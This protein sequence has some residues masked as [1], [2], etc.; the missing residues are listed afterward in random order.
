MH[1]FFLIVTPEGGASF[2]VQLM[3]KIVHL[4]RDGKTMRYLIRAENF[5]NLPE[6]LRE[7]DEHTG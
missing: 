3:K 2:H 6:I 7:L 5:D 4:S 1:L